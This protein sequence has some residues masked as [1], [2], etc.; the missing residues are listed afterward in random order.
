MRS[1]ALRR[2]PTPVTEAKCAASPKDSDSF[3]TAHELFSRQSDG[4]VHLYDVNKVTQLEVTMG[5]MVDGKWTTQWYEESEDGSFQRPDTVF[6]DWVKADGST[7]FKPEPGRY[8]LY[9]AW[10]C[11]WAHRTLLARKMKGLEDAV[12]VSV[13]A[14]F[15][16]EDGWTF[17]DDDPACI[18]DTVNGAEF[19]RDIYK[20]ADDR[21]TG[22]VTV[23]VLWDKKKKTIVNNESLD[24][25]QMFDQEFD[26]VATRDVTLFPEG[27]QDAI[28]ERID[29]F[30]N[31]VNNGVY[32]CGFA[33]TQEAY[34]EAF[35]EL[36]GK[37]DE[38]EELLGQQRYVM[39]DQFTLA[40][41][42]L[43]T[44]LLRFDIV[45]Y[46]HFKT[47]KRHIYEYPNLWGFTRD[48]YQMPGVT[49]TLNL[50]QTKEHYFTSHETVNPKR[51][52]AKG[53]EIDFDEPHDRGRFN[54]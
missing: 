23:P 28:L 17:T 39:G 54:S 20:L 37:L 16:G 50:A 18:P 27:M 21:Y 1:D 10:A 19:L 46:T 42:C 22:R 38:Y 13:V 51:F 25:I 43:W 34:E 32:R 2:K 29:D 4:D 8:H 31:P 30:Y 44:T 48:I 45:Y 9:V 12:N 33:T 49:E 6:H 24:I 41:I 7:E 14:P 26:S 11:P 53:P 3:A 15:M 47:N 40:D 52:I 5:R 35:D 36:F